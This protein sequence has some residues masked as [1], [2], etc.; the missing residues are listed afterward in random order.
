MPVWVFY[1]S[2]EQTNA[3]TDV[4]LTE[5][6]SAAATD[7]IDGPAKRTL[8]Q[9]DKGVWQ[10]DDLEALDEDPD[11]YRV[12]CSCGEEFGSWIEAARHVADYSK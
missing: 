2:M 4:T 6:L 12:E 8:T 10:P 5:H 11:G 3:T 7:S 1:V 9:I